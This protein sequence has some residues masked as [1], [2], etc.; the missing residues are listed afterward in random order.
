MTRITRILG[1]TAMLAAFAWPAAAVHA[2]GNHA[3]SAS[4]FRSAPVAVRTVF[5]GYAPSYASRS[6][7][8]PGQP[9][10]GPALSYIPPS[11]PDAP[12]FSMDGSPA[13][14]GWNWQRV[15]LQQIDAE[16]RAK[17]AAAAAR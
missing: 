8:Y 12:H 3:R 5:V 11:S 14:E 13:V 9:R 10:T 15:S 2:A 6:P 17:R 1:G 4:N 16:V 7:I